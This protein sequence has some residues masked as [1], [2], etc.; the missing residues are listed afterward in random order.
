MEQIISRTYKVA[1]VILNYMNYQETMS[2][3][4]SALQQKNVKFHIV[5]VDNGSS[6]DS[7]SILKKSYRNN[8]LVDVIRTKKNMGFAKG[9]NIGIAY[10]KHK[11]MTNFALLINSDTILVDKLYIAKMLGNYRPPIGVIGSAIISRDGKI[12]KRYCEYVDFPVTLVNYIKM[13]GYSSGVIK[14]EGKLEHKLNVF[15][16]QRSN[17]EILHGCAMMLTP[18]YLEKYSGLYDK[19]FLY[20]EEILLYLLCERA[21]LQQ[22]YISDIKIIH[23]EDQSSKYL[24]DNESAVKKKYIRKSYK[25]VVI[26]SLINYY[27]QRIGKCRYV[28]KKSD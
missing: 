28:E 13:L 15:L 7:Y 12:Q 25:F 4:E 19:T 8:L 20:C 3:V 23:K 21:G 16:N 17:T 1:I 6:N 5:V 27:L 11:Y 9:N 2:C 10:L 22:L 14:S 18:S 26:E 24:F